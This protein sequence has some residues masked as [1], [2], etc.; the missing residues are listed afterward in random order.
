[1]FPGK[2]EPKVPFG[3]IFFKALENARGNSRIIGGEEAEPREST[4]ATDLLLNNT[5][6]F[7]TSLAWSNLLMETWF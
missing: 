1:L 6:S 2:L 3:D 7:R 5:E 4:L